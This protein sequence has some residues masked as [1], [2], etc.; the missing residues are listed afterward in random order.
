MTRKHSPLKVLFNKKINT[1]QLYIYDT[2]RWNSARIWL[3][4]IYMKIHQLSIFFLT[5]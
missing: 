3:I 1:N 4:D 5:L 2:F